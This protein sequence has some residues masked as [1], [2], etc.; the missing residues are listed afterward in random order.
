MKKVY[1]LNRNAPNDWVKFK[2]WYRLPS[3]TI[4]FTAEEAWVQLLGRKLPEDDNKP[5][6]K[7]VK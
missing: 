6:K 1:H 2:R 5:V 7:K 3:L 4:P